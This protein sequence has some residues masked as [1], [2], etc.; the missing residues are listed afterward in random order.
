MKHFIPPPSFDPTILID[1]LEMEKELLA[2]QD[3]TMMEE[4]GDL[5]EGDDQGMVLE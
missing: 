4:D 1:M 3:N 2:Q 5:E